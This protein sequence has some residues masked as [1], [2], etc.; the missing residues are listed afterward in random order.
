[1]FDQQIRKLQFVSDLK[2]GDNIDSIF[3]VR[4]KSPLFPYKNGKQ[5]SWFSI[6]IADKTGKIEARFWGNESTKT[7]MIWNLIQNSDVIH[8]KGMVIRY[9][10]ALQISISGTDEIK[11][12]EKYSV[13]DFLPRSKKDI[14]EML[15]ELRSLLSE[16]KN[17]YIAT[18]V[19]SFLN[20]S[21]F[22]EKFSRCP[23]AVSRHQNYLGGLLEHTL[24]LIHICKTI[25]KDRP[26]LDK[27]LLLSG[28]FLH[29]IGKIRE[30]EISST[31]TISEEGRLIGHISIGQHMVEEKISKIDGFPK[32]LKLKLIHIIL[33]H[34]GKLEWGSPKEPQFSEALVIHLADQTDA[35]TDYIIKH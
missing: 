28:C 21:E 4:S 7:Q 30:Y 15:G 23:A 19:D 25:A 26:E 6:Q 32:D 18:L 3:A 11:N 29:D 5:G 16:M 20:D 12:V 24:N 8:V 33:S 1:M 17:P 34:H 2:E 10:Q 35:K 9:N 14:S 22:M 31:I 27:D 13:G